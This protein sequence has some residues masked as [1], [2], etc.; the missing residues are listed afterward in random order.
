MSV[1]NLARFFINIWHLLA[2]ICTLNIICV[3]HVLSRF[4]HFVYIYTLLQIGP[5]DALSGPNHHVLWLEAQSGALP[6]G[7]WCLAA[8]GSL[9]SWTPGRNQLIP[10][11]LNA[12]LGLLKSIVAYVFGS[13]PQA[14]RTVVARTSV[15]KNEDGWHLYLLIR[16][17]VGCVIR[18]DQSHSWCSRDVCRKNRWWPT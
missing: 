6:A 10:I 4:L 7:C 14:L 2:T 1:C 11:N 18:N 3:W 17:L 9:F 16:S 5:N 8:A 13:R 15:L 12:I